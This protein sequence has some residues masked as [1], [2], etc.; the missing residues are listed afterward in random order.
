M[1]LEGKT[2]D[3]LENELLNLSKRAVGIFLLCVSPRGRGGG[4][5][6]GGVKNC[7]PSVP[8]TAQWS[9]PHQIFDF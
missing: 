6:H 3:S 2:A 8:V 7:L 4:R 9:T 1:L 5:L